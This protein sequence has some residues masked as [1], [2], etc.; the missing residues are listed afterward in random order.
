MMNVSRSTRAVLVSAGVLGCA[1]ALAAQ[2]VL[3]RVVLWDADARQIFGEAIVGVASPGAAARPF[4]A[5]APSARAAVVTEA[6]AWARAY[7]SSAPFKKAWAEKRDQNKP[8][9]PALTGSASDDVKKQS[10][11]QLKQLDELKKT[12]AQ[13][14]PDQQK[15]MQ[16]VMDQ[17]VAQMN[18]AAKDPKYQA[19]MQQ[20]AESNRASKQKEY[21][22]AVASW[23]HD[24]PADPNVAIARRLRDFLTMSADVNFDAKLVTRNGGRTFADPAFEGKP[25]AWKMCFRAGRDATTAARAAA[26]TWLK[27]MGQ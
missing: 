17:M 11:D 18:D 12:I 21:Q 23:Q 27:E 8:D 24:Y 2:T 7:A 19:L 1:V 3:S 15:Q 26:Q 6:V 4:L 14:P 16:A 9:P 5:L 10:A 25:D 13:L 22:D 20:G